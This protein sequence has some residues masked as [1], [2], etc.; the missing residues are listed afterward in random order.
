MSQ[1]AKTSD[2][3][4]LAYNNS[5]RITDIVSKKQEII[6]TL[7]QFHNLTAS[8]ILFV[9]FSSFIFADHGNAKLFITKVSADILTYLKTKNIKIQYIADE[10]LDKHSK[11]FQLVIAVD[12]YFTHADSDLAQQKSVSQ[13]CNLAS[14]LVITTLRDYKNQDYKDREF[15]L[16]TLIKSTNQSLIFLEAN[17]WSHTDRNAWTSTIYQINNM[18]HTLVPFGPFNRRAMYFKQLAKFSLDAG[19]D[20]FLVHKNLMYKGL[21]KKNYEHVI[22]IKFD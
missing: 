9:G 11:E 2:A 12:E 1:F 21:F 7:S 3:N 22:T 5:N 14:E 13:I 16:P 19:A 18:G 17:E 15:G 6:D 8:S 4:F 20:S 10:D